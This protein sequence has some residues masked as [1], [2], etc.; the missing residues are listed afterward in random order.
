MAVQ[1][2]PLA[3][4]RTLAAHVRVLAMRASQRQGVGNATAA[5]AAVAT[6]GRLGRDYGDAPLGAPARRRITAYFTAVLRA[7]ALRDRRPEDREYLLLLK[8]AALIAYLRQAAF[9]E[10]EL[11][12]EVAAT[13]GR[14][15]VG[16]AERA[17]LLQS[18]NAAA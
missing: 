2:R 1:T 11:R 4:N 14:D 16:A 6:L 7:K 3:T 15:G 18:R 8:V 17:G 12:A 10:S 13:F 5:A 9:S